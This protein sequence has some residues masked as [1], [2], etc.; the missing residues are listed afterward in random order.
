MKKN[1]YIFGCSG[2]G[3]S[4]IDLRRSSAYTYET[5]VFVDQN[6]DLI[7]T[8]YYGYPV[9]HLSELESKKTKDQ[10]VIFA[11]FKP[12]DIFSRQK[13]I[14]KI[15]DKFKFELVSIVDP[16]AVVSPSATLGK[17]CYIAAFVYIDGDFSLRIIDYF[18]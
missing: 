13:Y 18:V 6:P 12:K 11:Y 14:D 16:S 17:G 1:L 9:L 8:M 4:I 2:T 15:I 7:G 5:I 3:K 10:H